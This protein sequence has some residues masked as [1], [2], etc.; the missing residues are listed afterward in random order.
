MLNAFL[1]GDLQGG[2]YR[3]SFTVSLVNDSMLTGLADLAASD[4]VLR[5]KLDVPKLQA[6]HAHEDT[7]GPAP[8]LSPWEHKTYTCS[9]L[10]PSPPQW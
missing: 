6:S 8:G 2:D 4:P 5:E 1:R 9:T 10:I 3:G 7:I